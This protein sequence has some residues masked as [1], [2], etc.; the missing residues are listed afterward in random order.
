MCLGIRVLHLSR[1]LAVHVFGV[2]SAFGFFLGSFCVIAKDEMLSVFLVCFLSV[3]IPELWVFICNSL[4]LR[5][6][7]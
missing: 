1:L 4:R 2:F 7:F 6:V 3:L 5:P